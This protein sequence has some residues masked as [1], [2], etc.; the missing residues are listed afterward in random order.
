MART[1]RPPKTDW[2]EC[3]VEGC[4]KLTKNGSKGM[5]HTHYMAARRG[6]IDPVTGKELR[7]KKRVESYGDGARCSIPSCGRRPKGRGLC[8]M[9][10]QQWAQ[11]IEWPGIDIP[12]RGHEKEAISYRHAECIVEGCE[13]RPI[14][15][16]MCN[17]HTLQ[18]EAGIIDGEGNKL[19][20]LIT[21]GRR[22]KE[23]RATKHGYILVRAPLGHP[24]ARRDGSILEHRLVM[25]DLIGRY[26]EPYEIIHHTDGDP[27][28]NHPDNLQLMDG[29]ARSRDRHPPGHEVDV[30]HAVR[31]LL[32]QED[33][34]DGARKAIEKYVGRKK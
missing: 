34:P 4:S 32:Q 17:K 15:R 10:Y 9:H 14:N 13:K 20:E 25:E 24:G 30:H 19:R 11:G 29:R 12:D 23:R 1:G 3:K 31:V 5:C 18:R 26:L 6:R 16:W 7:P 28:N 33:L 27:G 2:P 21:P 22:P 8:T